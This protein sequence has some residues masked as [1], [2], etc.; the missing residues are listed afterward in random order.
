M[1][2]S[3]PQDN[4]SFILMKD[5]MAEMANPSQHVDWNKD[6]LMKVLLDIN[7]RRQLGTLPRRC[8][9]QWM[10]VEPRT[11]TAVSGHGKLVQHREQHTKVQKMCAARY[12]NY[13]H[14]TRVPMIGRIAQDNKAG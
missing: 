10:E 7:N 12:P 11:A 5:K 9:S 14:S 1:Q 6:G 8:W 2:Q 4:H 13:S 3:M